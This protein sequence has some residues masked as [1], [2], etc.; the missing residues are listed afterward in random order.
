MAARHKWNRDSV[1]FVAGEMRRH[2]G[3]PPCRYEV[4]CENCRHQAMVLTAARNPQFYCSRCGDRDP[5][6]KRM[7][8]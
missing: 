5:I 7:L 4:R 1:R 3:R 8:R 2:C 6:V